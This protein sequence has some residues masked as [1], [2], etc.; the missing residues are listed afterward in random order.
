[1]SFT[2]ALLLQW[3]LPKLEFQILKSV[4]CLILIVHEKLFLDIN[5]ASSNHVFVRFLIRVRAQALHHEIFCDSEVFVLFI[6]IGH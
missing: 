1:M 5:H 2:D 6:E 4:C 3:H